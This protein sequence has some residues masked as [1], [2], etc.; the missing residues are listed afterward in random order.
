[1]LRPRAARA[2]SAVLMLVLG[3]AACGASTKNGTT[4]S[5]RDFSLIEIGKIRVQVAANGR[6]AVVQVETDPPTVCAIA[7]GTTASLGSIADDADMGGTAISRHTVILSGLTPGKSY[8]FRLTAT[9][10]RARLPDE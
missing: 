9:D 4:T 1:M 5:I 10:A 7:Y 6:S 2:L 8:L 3:L